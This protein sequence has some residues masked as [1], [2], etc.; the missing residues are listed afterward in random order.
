MSDLR[1]RIF[2]FARDLQL[3]NLATLAD[4]GRP[5]VRYVVGRADEDLVVRFSTHLDS[6]KVRQLRADGRV[7][8]TLGATDVRSPLWLQLD[9]TASIDTSETARHAFWFDGL[10]RHFTGVDDPRYCIVTVTPDRIALG[11]EIWEASRS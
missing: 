8:L 9:G 10:R 6:D 5:L 3:I 2:R 7:C 4:D 11:P 1:H